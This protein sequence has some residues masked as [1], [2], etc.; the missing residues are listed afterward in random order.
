MRMQKSPFKKAEPILQRLKEHG[1]Q[2]FFVGGCVRDLLLNRPIGDIDIATSAKPWQVQDIFEKVLPVGMEHGT[3]I[4]RHQHESYEVTTFRLD[5]TYSDFR[6]PDQ[7]EFIQTIEQDLQRRDF[8]IN[9]MAMDID[10]NMIDPF[11]GN[12]DLKRKRIRTVGK[13]SER[14]HEDPLRMIRA[15]R[16]ASQLG[17]AIEE[18]TQTSMNKQQEQIKDLAV[19]RITSE[20]TKLFA[21]SFVNNGLHYLRETQIYQQLPVISEYPDIISQIPSSLRPLQSFAEVI[22]LFHVLEPSIT[23]ESWVRQWKCSNKQKQEAVQ[24]T[25]AWYHYK[26]YGL[27]RWLTYRLDSMFFPGF[28]RVGKNLDEH[29]T[30]STDELEKLRNC[31]PIRSLP[32][33]AV[34]GNDLQKLFPNKR[35]GPWIKHFLGV[36]EKKVVY[37]ELTNNKNELKEWITWNPPEIN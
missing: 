30:L 35:K 17:F 6:H 10:G 25:N 23:I 8:T 33:L 2:A 5:G 7:V 32:E 4:V 37:G 21:G 14:F 11:G 29:V 9:A 19:E 31:L 3:V 28:V 27:D 13:A 24:L 36:L 1:Y 12:M 34:N 15:L 16:F 18:T 26:A 22:A 20:V